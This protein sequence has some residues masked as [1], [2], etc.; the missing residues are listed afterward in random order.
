MNISD[1]RFDCNRTCKN[2]EMVSVLVYS[3]TNNY[4]SA[5]L[6]LDK[7]M[8]LPSRFDSKTKLSKLIEHQK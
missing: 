3:G 5:K 2:F 4:L 1:R 8:D 6:Y 7:K